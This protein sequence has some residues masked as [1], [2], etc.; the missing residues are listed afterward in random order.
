MAQVAVVILNYNGKHFLEQFLPS[1][2]NCSSQSTVYVADSASTDGS[3]AWLKGHYPDLPLIE[4][5]ANYGYAGGYNRALSQITAETL[6]CSTP[7]WK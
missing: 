7:T 4:L 5:P 1:V 3:V 6:C 2:L